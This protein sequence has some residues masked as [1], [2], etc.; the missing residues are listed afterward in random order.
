[1]NTSDEITKILTDLGWEPADC[2][3]GETPYGATNSSYFCTCSGEKYIIRLAA[4]NSD[5][6]VINRKAELAAM[7][8]ARGADWC[9]PLVYFNPENGNMVTKYV[10]ADPITAEQFC[11]EENIIKMASI[12]KDLHGR[13]TDYFFNPYDDVE[14]KLGY[15]KRHNIPMHENF[16]EAYE[17]Y[18]IKRD[19]NPAFESGFLGLCHNDITPGNCLI[20]KDGQKIYLIDYEFS[21]MGNIF[22]DLLCIVHYLPEEKQQLFFRQYFGEYKE[23]M[24][25]KVKDFHVIVLMWNVTWA[26]LKTLDERKSPEVD[27]MQHANEWIDAILGM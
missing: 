4:A 5:L 13:K 12:I 20:S 3:I 27:Y 1:L 21:G 16:D 14:K 22:N 19:R 11:R 24:T 26:Y 23:Y 2:E 17:I 10:D 9:L 18:G 6:L 15:I 7:E 25:Q 8:A